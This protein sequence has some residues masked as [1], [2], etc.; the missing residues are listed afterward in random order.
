MICGQTTYPPVVSNVPLS[1]VPPIR[2]FGSNRLTERLWNCSVESRLFRLYR[3]V[4]TRESSC[5]QSVSPPPESPRAAHWDE[6]SAKAPL[7]RIRPPSEPSKN[8][9]GLLG[10]TTSACWS[11]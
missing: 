4:G 2:F 9:L 11:G 6:T 8:I 1:C 10:L 7:E 3:Y 5:W